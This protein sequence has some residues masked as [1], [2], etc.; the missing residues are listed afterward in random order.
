MALEEAYLVHCQYR[1]KLTWL[2]ATAQT[3]A[4]SDGEKALLDPEAN[5][6]GL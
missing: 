4:G 1:A 3:N 6:V 5:S 2:G